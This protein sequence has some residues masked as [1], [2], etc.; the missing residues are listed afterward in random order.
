S[1]TRQRPDRLV[2]G[3]SRR[4]A[5]I[6]PGDPVANGLRAGRM[7]RPCCTPAAEGTTTAQE[8]WHTGDHCSRAVAP[9]RPLLESSG[10]HA[11]LLP[12]VGA[13]GRPPG[14]PYATAD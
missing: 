8:Q 3:A 12:A 1:A 6:R 14:A 10:T 7:Q 5:L 13:R 9:R 4:T 2:A 11:G